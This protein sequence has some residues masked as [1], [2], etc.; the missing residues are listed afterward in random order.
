MRV[1]IRSIFYHQT[2]YNQNIVTVLWNS[3]FCV[4]TALSLYCLPAADFLKSA[5]KD[6]PS[7]LY[8]VKYS[9][10]QSLNFTTAADNVCIVSGDSA[11]GR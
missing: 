7:W 3:R 6:D 2:I 11:I 9:K 4:T 8:A 5:N 1:Q 10:Q